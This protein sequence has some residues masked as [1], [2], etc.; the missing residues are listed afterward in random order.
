MP[1]YDPLNIKILKVK[2]DGFTELKRIDSLRIFEKNSQNFDRRG[3][4]STEVFGKVGTEERQSRLGIINLKIKALH[5]LIYRTLKEL[6]KLYLDIMEGNAYAVFNNKTKEFEMSNPDNGEKGFDFFIRHFK[7]IEFKSTDSDSRDGKIKLIK[8]YDNS[9]FVIT[10]FPVLP[11]GLRDYTVK[12]GKPSEDAINDL[13]RALLRKSNVLDNYSFKDTEDNYAVDPI[14]SSI[15]KTMLAI[16]EHLE[17]LMDGKSKLIAGKWA[18]RAIVDGTM[19]VATPS[20]V[21]ITDTSS[22]HIA[23]Y[24]DTVVGLFQYLKMIIRYVVYAIK[25]EFL[26]NVFEQYNNNAKLINKASLRQESVTVSNNTR[27]KWLTSD[28]INNTINK[29]FNKNIMESP[30]TIE[31][32]YLALVYEDNDIIS[33]VYNIDRLPDGISKDKLRPITYAELFYLAVSRVAID[34]RFPAV[35]SRYPTAGQ[36][37]IYPTKLYVKTTVKSK[38]VKWVKDLNHPEDV[39]M[40][41]EYPK[42]GEAFMNTYSVHSS[43][44]N[45]LGLDYDGDRGTLTALMTDQSINEINNVLDSAPYYLNN[46]SK[47]AYSAFDG[48]LNFVL[49]TLGR[50]RQ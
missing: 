38:T 35:T 11:A 40:V 42:I 37:G 5:P 36:G 48:N 46:K 1:N 23:S 19:N 9:G 3:L 26:N 6:N 27:E 28:G 4:F 14:R 7:D 30:I 15:Q 33:V 18:K 13:Y 44:I 8:K 21:Q 29:L 20:S 45:L 50:K 41:Y 17:S 10:K 49:K 12:D 43:H 16:Y 25:A 47:L 22:P 2:D 24:N 34:K 31:D 32:R 39:T